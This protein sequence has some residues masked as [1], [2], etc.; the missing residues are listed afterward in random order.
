[1]HTNVF[2]AM[3]RQ[4]GDRSTRRRFL[5]LLGGAAA[6][7]AS[8]AITGETEAG[9]H[10]RHRRRHAGRRQTGKTW[11]PDLDQRVQLP[12]SVLE[13]APVTCTRWALSGGPSPSDPIQAD[14]DLVIT[15]NTT[16]GDGEHLIVDDSSHRSEPL[17][18]PIE[19]EAQV[20]DV[21][22]VRARDWGGCRSLSP[23]WLHCKLAKTHRMVFPGYS[24]AHCEYGNSGETFLDFLVEVY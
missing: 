22:H 9:R 13:P 20:G 21:L 8:V 14:D 7:G 5:R 1:M 3:T 18:A 10:R 24:G 2:D 12:D 15:I 19:F 23:L 17:A 16:F 6:V 4:L 11:S